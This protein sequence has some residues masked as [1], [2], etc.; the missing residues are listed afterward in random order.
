MYAYGWSAVKAA[1][2]GSTARLIDIARQPTTGLSFEQ[3]G[4]AGVRWHWWL[5]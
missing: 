1:A 2:C 5:W 4:G 3:V